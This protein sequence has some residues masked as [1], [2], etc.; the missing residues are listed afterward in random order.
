M[1]P[2]FSSTQINIDG[3]YIKTLEFAGG[4]IIMCTDKGIYLYIKAQGII[5][6]QNHFDNAVSYEDFH[7]VTISQFEYEQND[8]IALYKNMI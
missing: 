5:D 3:K 6:M 1:Q 7:F 8:L 4:N 2:I